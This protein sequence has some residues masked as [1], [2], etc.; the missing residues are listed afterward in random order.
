MTL[1]E[2]LAV[3]LYVQDMPPERRDNLLLRRAWGVIAAHALRI[4]E[5]DK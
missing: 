3:W 2:A 4:I 5:R 1:E